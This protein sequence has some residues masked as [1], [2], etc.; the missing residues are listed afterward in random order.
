MEKNKTITWIIL[1][2]L[3]IGILYFSG[4][5]NSLGLFAGTS[6][7][8]GTTF[9]PPVHFFVVVLDEGNPV[10]D[11]KVEVKHSESDNFACLQSIGN[12]PVY[13]DKEGIAWGVVLPDSGKIGYVGSYDIYVDGNYEKTFSY[14][15]GY[16][17]VVYVGT[18]YASMSGTIYDE[19][20]NPV[21]GEIR[22]ELLSRN[23]KDEFQYDYW[24]EF[25]PNYDFSLNGYSKY[26]PPGEYD[27]YADAVSSAYKGPYTEII[28]INPNEN[29]VK[30]IYLTLTNPGIDYE[31][32]LG[33]TKCVD[34][35]IYYTC[36]NGAWNNEGRLVGKCGV[37][38]KEQDVVSVINGQTF[39]CKDYKL[40][41]K[42]DMDCYNGDLR[43]VNG[44]TQYCSNDKWINTIYPCNDVD[45]KSCSEG[46]EECREQNLYV[47]YEGELIPY[48]KQD[49]KCGYTVTE[50]ITRTQLGNFISQWING[51]I[52]RNT[53]GSKIQ[54]WIIQN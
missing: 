12:Q 35:Y 52:D 19:E 39:V 28:T 53:L 38:C 2:I 36:L 4:N 22:V 32:T 44:K 49:G 26:I 7:G 48:G 6:G 1:G 34:K 45:Y 21:K 30:D 29:I 46:E 9:T 18:G 23:P 47:C 31:C 43:C 5:L 10:Q 41:P 20:G 15:P 50:T 14:S 11:V 17:E 42:T 25:G 16:I 8:C 51:D 24:N 33:Q 27:F 13:T 37:E 54:L 3:L 40:Y